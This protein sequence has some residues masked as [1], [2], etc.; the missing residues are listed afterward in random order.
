MLAGGHR[1]DPSLLSTRRASGWKKHRTG[2]V[3]G[4][5]YPTNL[6]NLLAERP[7][8]PPRHSAFYIAQRFR[9]KST[10]CAPRDPLFLRTRAT[11]FSWNRAPSHKR[12]ADNGEVTAVCNKQT[13]RATI[14]ALSHAHFRCLTQAIEPPSTSTSASEHRQPLGA[15]TRLGGGSL[16]ED[17]RLCS[18]AMEVRCCHLC[19]Q[20]L[21]TKRCSWRPRSDRRYVPT[22]GQSAKCVGV[23]QSLLLRTPPYILPTGACRL[24]A[25]SVAMPA[26]QQARGPGQP[27]RN[28][29]RQ[30]RV[31]APEAAERRSTKGVHRCFRKCCP[32]VVAIYRLL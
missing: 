10:I 4:K 15:P 17:L 28:T 7:W 30:R 25:S 19:C 1:N 16:V 20:V 21:T 5:L 29:R 9:P 12:R 2:C 14:P 23:T 3:S 8:T 6:P 24:L 11:G 18:K 26:V 27:A 31:L 13:P 32:I 22:A